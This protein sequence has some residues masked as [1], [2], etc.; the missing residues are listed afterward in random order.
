MNILKAL[1]NG[2]D[3]LKLN[4]ID[5]YKID[6]ELL[7]SDSLNISRERL[8]LNFHEIIEAENYENFLSKL[9]RRQKKEPVAY[10]VN[11]KEFWKIKRKFIN[12]KSNRSSKKFLRG[13]FTKI[14]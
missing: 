13:L 12:T 11:K 7:L 5:S 10:I 6:T 2:Y 4:K 3:L 8:I 14:Y 1:H 9:Y